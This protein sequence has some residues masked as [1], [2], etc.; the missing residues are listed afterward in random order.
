MTVS[1]IGTSTAAA[2]AKGAREAQRPNVKALR[3]ALQTGDL[4]AAREAF[5]KIYKNVKAAPTD[6]AHDG[7]ASNV[8]RLIKAVDSGDIRA[9]QD[10]LKSI[11]DDR[12]AI[13][14]PGQLPD[15]VRQ[16]GQDF[17]SLV[18]A[19]R[20]GDANAAS[21]A[22]HDLRVELKPHFNQ[23]EDQFQILPM[24]RPESNAEP[25]RIQPMPAP[26][27]KVPEAE[28]MTTLPVKTNV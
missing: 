4:N 8:K 12:K 17:K 21:A 2:E 1:G 25:A 3:E 27:P 13:Y 23:R 9:A 16:I 22:L 24:G 20:S 10:S 26:T 6:A 11:P 18:Q 14:S 5:A 15:P 19:V 7:I 28:P